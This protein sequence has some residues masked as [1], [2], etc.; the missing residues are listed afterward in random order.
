MRQWCK[1]ILSRLAATFFGVKC[2]R[3]KCRGASL[4]IDA[5]TVSKSVQR[6]RAVLSANIKSKGECGALPALSSMSKKLTFGFDNEEVGTLSVEDGKF[7]ADGEAADQILQLARD[8]G[9]AIIRA[10]PEMDEADLTHEM[11]MNR[12]A[13]NAQGR[14]HAV[15][16]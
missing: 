4:V 12:L 1:K 10:N 3:C 8:A 5:A 6:R 7:V 14:F 16:K 13:A 11:I 9:E 2:D 15:L